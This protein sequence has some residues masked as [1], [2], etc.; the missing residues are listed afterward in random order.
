MKGRLLVIFICLSIFQETKV[1][2]QGFIFEFNI[3]DAENGLPL[4]DVFVTPLDLKYNTHKSVFSIT[5]SQGYCNILIL[6]K[7]DSFYI[8][9]LGYRDTI[10]ANYSTSKI[11]LIRSQN[12]IDE[13]VINEVA[14]RQIFNKDTINLEVQHYRKGTEKKIE[15][16]LKKIP[17]VDVDEK[18]II[19]YQG[20]LVSRVLIDNDDLLGHN[21]TLGTRNLSA[22]MIKDVSIYRNYSDDPVKASVMKTNLTAL[23]I[24]LE[25]QFK[26]AFTALGSLGL[27][28]SSSEV[29]YAHDLITLGVFRRYKNLFFIGANNTRNTLLS[30]AQFESGN[31]N[32]FPLFLV[33]HIGQS[34]ANNASVSENHI[35]KGNQKLSSLHQI[36]KISNQLTIRVNAIIGGNS[37]TLREN[38]SIDFFSS[39]PEVRFIDSL[40]TF[41]KRHHAEV[42][43]QIRYVHPENEHSVSFDLQWINRPGN[44]NNEVHRNNLS[45]NSGFRLAQNDQL[46]QSRIDISRSWKK[47]TLYSLQI[48]LGNHQLNDENEYESPV[49]YQYVNAMHETN[50][51]RQKDRTSVKR[52]KVENSIDFARKNQLTIKVGS[53]RQEFST[54]LSQLLNELPVASFTQNKFKTSDID[55]YLSTTYQ[56]RGKFIKLFA[57]TTAGIRNI[58]SQEKL[59]AYINPEVRISI[60]LPQRWLLQLNAQRKQ[61][62]DDIRWLAEQRYISSYASIEENPG[63]FSWNDRIDFF[64][65]ITKESLDKSW[66]LSMNAKYQNIIMEWLTNPFFDEGVSL[67]RYI[68]TGP[69]SVAKIGVKGDHT[70]TKLGLIGELGIYSTQIKSLIFLEKIEPLSTCILEF[71]S[72]IRSGFENFNFGLTFQYNKYNSEITKLSD[73]ILHQ[74]HTGISLRYQHLKF[75]NLEHQVKLTHQTGVGL[76]GTSIV[77]NVECN[78]FPSNIKH[79]SNISL[80]AINPLNV[81]N[82]NSVFTNAFLTTT[83]SVI[84]VEPFF[85]V[86]LSLELNPK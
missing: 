84:A 76:S 73:R 16:L 34:E 2:G 3:F 46:I 8:S 40:N 31:E 79:L 63:R 51:F 49:L 57:S 7:I 42:N 71:K 69:M 35:A 83:R 54:Q 44:Y 86:S 33:R 14:N 85:L 78:I 53:Q 13:I 43:S 80:S 27:G 64:A 20:D 5:N 58:K 36:T 62:F 10:I 15:D 1:V 67:L 59:Y 72:G 23:N 41:S 4:E 28:G 18:G 47:K 82:F 60:S 81:K 55:Y 12:I 56:I 68:Y 39:F 22:D 50:I 77:S 19:R 45:E 37:I 11:F 24:S 26:S 25:N 70:F 38:Q 65:A 75:W 74:S 30:N 48:Y 32:D 9:K 21:Y 52:F 66:T 61:S 17:G 6:V 29:R